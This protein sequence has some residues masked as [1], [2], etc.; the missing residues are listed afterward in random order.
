MHPLLLNPLTAAAAAA[1]VTAALTAIYLL[2]NRFR[3]RPVSSL[4]LWR[5]ARE[6]REG[7]LKIRR[8]HVPLLF[9]VEL[10]ALALLCLAAAEPHVRMSQ[11]ARPL[12]VVLDDSFSMNAGG[13]DCPRRRALD[14]LDKELRDNPPYSIRF[15]LAGDR[16]MLLGDAVR[17]RGEAMSLAE[18]WRCR[19]SSA[20]I[21]EAV[22]LGAELGGQIAPPLVLVLTDHAPPKPLPEKGRLCWWSFGRPTGNVAIV[23]A[24]R[25]SRDGLDRCL[26]EVANLSDEPRAVTLT[27]E[28]VGSG[29]S[30]RTDELALRA[31]AS[32]R[33]IVQLSPG[34]G[35]IRAYVDADDLTID[36]EVVL[37]PQLPR[38]VRYDVQVRDRRLREPLEKAVAATHAATKGDKRPDLLFTDRR[39]RLDADANTWVVHLISE[40]DATAYTGPFV[41][42]RAHPLTEGMS[43]NGLI[44]GAGKSQ[45]LDGSPIVLA[46]NVPLLSDAERPTPGGDP[47]HEIRLRLNPVLSTIYDSSDWPIFIWNLLSWRAGSMSGPSRTNVR[48]G[49]QVTINLPGHRETVELTSPGHSPRT[50][51]VNGRQMAVRADEVGVHEVKVDETTYAF[52][53]NALSRDESDLR[54]CETA[55]H[56][57][58][59]DE[60]ALRLEYSPAAWIALLVALGLV[61]LHLWLT[62]RKVISDQ[63]SVIRP[64]RTAPA[65]PGR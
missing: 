28:S 1:T 38:L 31:G 44:W 23:N 33:V 34:A 36:D 40:K 47:R 8:L 19:S 65:A 48:L 49:E 3:R 53:A 64:D 63:S 21:D 42:D 54:E 55:R 10:L 60:T 6:A 51:A 32:Q 37:Q 4:M 5:D 45:A 59:L 24:A 57:D 7:G 35:P 27:V 52:A 26:I 2:R 50:V 62:A 22:A 61:T 56:G 39:D 46:G 25:T 15:V 43:L 13:D 12:V 41:I 29:K 11:G 9:F 14:A 20:R 17:S 58:W 16:P 30:L 18:G